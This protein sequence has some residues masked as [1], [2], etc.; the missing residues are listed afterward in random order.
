VDCAVREGRVSDCAVR[1]GRVSGLC[2]ARGSC[3]S[4]G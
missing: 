4:I 2:S 1:E 3:E